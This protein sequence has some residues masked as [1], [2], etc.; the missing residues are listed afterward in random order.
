M[1]SVRQPTQLEYLQGS[2]S[3]A[4]Q[5]ATGATANGNGNV[6][7]TAGYN[8]AIILEI[9]E[10]A[11]GTA[12]VALQGSF[13]KNTWYAVGYQQIDNIATPARAVANLAVAASVGHVYGVIDRYPFMRA[14]LSAVA[15]GAA[16]IVRLYCVPIT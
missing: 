3:S 6:V 11:G 2:P 15:G 8:G 14:V 10:T 7:Y 13:D 9:Q 12:T 1:S 4:V 5:G 16:V